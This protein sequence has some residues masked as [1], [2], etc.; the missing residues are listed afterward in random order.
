MGGRTEPDAERRRAPRRPSP[1][2]RQQARSARGHARSGDHRQAQPPS[3]PSPH[4]VHCADLCHHWRWSHGR[5]GVA[6]EQFEAELE[7]GWFIKNDGNIE[8]KKKKKKK[9]TCVDT[10][11]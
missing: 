4:L 9:S 8:K 2:L 6:L 5:F 10:T 1:H 11:A 7:G 3:T